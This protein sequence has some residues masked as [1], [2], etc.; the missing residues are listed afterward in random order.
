M[1]NSLEQYRA[2]VGGFNPVHAKRLQTNDRCGCE[3]SES[4][5]EYNRANTK[6]LTA[7][8]DDFDRNRKMFSRKQ[9]HL[10]KRKIN[11]MHVD[12]MRNPQWFYAS[13]WFVQLYISQLYDHLIDIQFHQNTSALQSPMY[14]V[15]KRGSQME[16]NQNRD[17][18]KKIKITKRTKRRCS[19]YA[20]VWTLQLY[21]RQIYKISNGTDF[22]P[23][24][25]KQGVLMLS[26]D[27][28]TNPGPVS[29]IPP[30]DAKSNTYLMLLSQTG[31]YGKKRKLNQNPPM[32]KRCRDDQNGMQ[33]PQSIEIES[34]GVFKP[35]T[36]TFKK[37]ISST[38]GLSYNDIK[39]TYKQDINILQSNPKETVSIV[40]DGNC[41]FRA[42]SYSLSN[43]EESHALVRSILTKSF[44]NSDCTTFICQHSGI[45]ESELQNHIRTSNMNTDGIWGTAIEILATCF[46]F[47][48]RVV[49]YEGNNIWNRFGNF[50]LSIP[51]IYL[52][53]SSNTHYNVVKSVQQTNAP[54]PSASH[55]CSEKEPITINSVVETNSWNS[56]RIACKP[57][58]GTMS[59]HDGVFAGSGY[60]TNCIINC[61]SFILK[62]ITNPTIPCDPDYIDD[63]LYRGIILYRENGLSGYLNMDDIPN[64]ILC[65]GRMFSLE[66]HNYFGTLEYWCNNEPVKLDD[67]IKM[68]LATH[69]ACLITCALNTTCIYKKDTKE[70]NEYY[71][72][73]PHRRDSK[74]CFSEDGKALVMYSNSLERIISI[75][76]QT[77]Q[78]LL[79]S[80]RD[81]SYG[82][83][84]FC[85][86]A[87]DIQSDTHMQP[88]YNNCVPVR[89]QQTN[90]LNT[91]NIL[92]TNKET[93]TI[94]VQQKSSRRSK[95]AE[96]KNKHKK[97]KERDIRLKNS[98]L[99]SENLAQRKHKERERYS[100]DEQYRTKKNID[101]KTKY[102]K[103]KC[104]RE[105]TITY[106]KNKYALNDSYREK[107]KLHNI[108][109]YAEN[110]EFRIKT[111]LHNIEKYAA[112]EQFRE[113]TKLHNITKYAENGEFRIKTK[114]HNIEKYAA[115]EQ[116]RE[117]TKLHNITNILCI[118]FYIV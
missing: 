18:Q 35:L 34:F 105:A 58:L 107:T 102:A 55:T 97:K 99:N 25:L 77:M 50:D 44:V 5:P 85:V 65:D 40:G 9:I 103:N 113:K 117:K 52:D 1:G 17:S 47:N 96:T 24:R 32:K 83:T 76:W 114:L 42:I 73:D 49:T 88:E 64:P 3:T 16:I 70:S 79:P 30:A 100:V 15:D 116:F 63:T 81:Q 92:P 12:K 94:K 37:A 59:Q 80:V 56:M 10:K 43:D 67:C 19:F 109:K 46:V 45:Q 95:S 31:G 115:N 74:G 38:Y 87:L 48:L 21:L 39:A 33:A 28:E 13:K 106:N 108:I 118:L 89:T 14:L 104:Y 82:A 20:S 84:P 6:P 72:F 2:A 93:E 111:K 36:S 22:D 7:M 98:Q 53:H 54:I 75:V 62:H 41:L 90:V 61:M 86:D 91:E 23:A 69:T 68:A 4:N 71:L 66:F 101:S 51:C 26:G 110:G 60:G 27:V 57:I 8:F 112:N 29:L 78:S 11:R